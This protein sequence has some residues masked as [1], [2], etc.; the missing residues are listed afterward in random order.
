MEN[1][2]K[3]DIKYDY[4]I[5]VLFSEHSETLIGGSEKAVKKALKTVKIQTLIQKSWTFS[6]RKSLSERLPW[7]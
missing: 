2:R 1:M 3:F 7:I 5:I 4:S 6:I